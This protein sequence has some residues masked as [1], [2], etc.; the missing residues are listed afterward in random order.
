[1]ILYTWVYNII[2]VAG[3]LTLADSLFKSGRFWLDAKCDIFDPSASVGLDFPSVDTSDYFR[4]N[5]LTRC[6]IL[7]YLLEVESSTLIT[8]LG[9]YRLGLLPK[10]SP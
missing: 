9:I 7:K 2:G 1:M 10:D 3:W 8:P 6:V 5:A 4:S